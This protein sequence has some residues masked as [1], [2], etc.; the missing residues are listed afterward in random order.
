[1]SI[2][3]LVTLLSGDQT[4]I[5]VAEDALVGVLRQKAQK[6][7]NASI[8]PLITASG[9]LLEGPTTLKQAGLRDGDAVTAILRD[10]S[11]A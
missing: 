3:V 5:S 9:S 11:G 7:L 1:M 10:I 6:K 8:G 2:G 4:C